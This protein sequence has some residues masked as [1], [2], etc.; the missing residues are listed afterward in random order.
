MA[1][2][3]SISV[4]IS[5]DI[6]AF[7]ES[8]RF[9]MNC[10]VRKEGTSH[11]DLEQTRTIILER[12]VTATS[13]KHTTILLLFDHEGNPFF[14]EVFCSDVPGFRSER[15]D[16]SPVQRCSGGV[17]LVSPEVRQE[18]ADFPPDSDT[19]GLVRCGSAWRSQRNPGGVVD[20]LVKQSKG[21]GQR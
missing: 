1:C 17:S 14:L 11:S 21:V 18:E 12:T 10:H 13:L 16:G 6:F 5:Q 4:K 3:F 9:G 8:L 20:D 19:P 15:L 2:S 7:P